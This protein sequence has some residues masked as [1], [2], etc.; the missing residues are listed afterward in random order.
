MPST[1]PPNKSGPDQAQPNS[2]QAQYQAR[3]IH[4]RFTGVSQLP[5]IS[6][7]TPLGFSLS[8]AERSQ[9][10]LTGRSC[11]LTGKPPVPI[12]SI[13]AAARRRRR[14]RSRAAILE[15]LVCC[16]RSVESRDGGVLDSGVPCRAGISRSA[17]ARIP[18]CP[19]REV[20]LGFR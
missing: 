16:V 10:S 17:C 9:A 3:P 4:G 14:R 18:F 12:R 8:V 7:S 13:S 15:W 19:M 11:S 1:F 2:P 5:H 20:F 6:L